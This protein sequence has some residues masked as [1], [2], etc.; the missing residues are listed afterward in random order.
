MAFYGLIFIVCWWYPVCVWVCVCPSQWVGSVLLVLVQWARPC[1]RQVELQG[2]FCNTWPV[3]LSHLCGW[4]REGKKSRGGSECEWASERGRGGQHKWLEGWLEGWVTMK[5]DCE[6]ERE[7]Q[8][9][10]PEGGKMRWQCLHISSFLLSLSLSL[11]IS[12][13]HPSLHPCPSFSSLSGGPGSVAPLLITHP[14][15]LKGHKYKLSTL[16]CKNIKLL[17]V[18]VAVSYRESSRVCSRTLT[19]YVYLSTCENICSQLST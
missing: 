11:A 17:Y 9:G 5:S 10:E 2:E 19:L 3:S 7:Q 6:R 18:T 8:L 4:R 12:S 15:N 16:K 13:P 14:F 1:I